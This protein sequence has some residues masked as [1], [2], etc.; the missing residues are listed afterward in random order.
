[1]Q[2]AVAEADL[3]VA[4][5]ALEV[6]AAAL[7]DQLE[8]VLEH[9]LEIVGGASLLGSV[10]GRLDVDAERMLGQ[11]AA[12]PRPGA[13]RDVGLPGLRILPGRTE[14]GVRFAGVVE[15]VLAGS[16]TLIQRIEAR[17]RPTTAGASGPEL[18]E[19]AL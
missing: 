4:E 9:A 13:A 3:R 17:Q 16:D 15:M 8:A 6:E 11:P 12:Q 14:Q 7:L 1:M 18:V 5:V 19:D 10:A 2:H